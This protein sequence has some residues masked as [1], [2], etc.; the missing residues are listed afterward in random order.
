L[1]YGIGALKVTPSMSA[2]GAVG[3]LEPLL[4]GKTRD[5]VMV[6][7]LATKK[8]L[9]CLP[10][11]VG[12]GTNDSVPCRPRQVYRRLIRASASSAIVAHLHPL[13]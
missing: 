3:I 4:R 9:V 6:L 8:R 2:K 11:T 13:T 5:V 1:E 10:I 12:V 7:A